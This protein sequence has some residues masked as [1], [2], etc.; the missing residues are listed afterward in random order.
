MANLFS[1]LQMAKLTYPIPRLTPVRTLIDR[2]LEGVAYRPWYQWAREETERGAKSLGIPPQ[3]FADLLAL[4]SPKVSV[5]RS[6]KFAIA[7]AHD[8]AFLHDVMRSTRAAVTHYQQT[9]IIRGP[10]TEAFSR[11]IMG[12]AD[13]I[14]LDSWMGTALHVDP[15]RW[16]VRAVYRAGAKRIRKVA[17]ILDW[18]PAET[19]AAIWAATVQENRQT[20]PTL[21]LMPLIDGIPI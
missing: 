17:A 7:Y 13:A 14:V 8:G 10:K 3:S 12:D 16:E 20:V 11:A 1:G 2:A 19:Q 15:K 4:F 9:G 21:S 6:A 5:L 18:T